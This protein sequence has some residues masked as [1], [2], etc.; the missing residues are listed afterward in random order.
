V[1]IFY[2][3][4]HKPFLRERLAKEAEEAL[5][6]ARQKAEDDAKREVQEQIWRMEQLENTELVVSDCLTKVSE[7][8]EAEKQQ[9]QVYKLTL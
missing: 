9:K 4:L 3:L 5:E 7:T 2:F 8:E 6:A 1:A